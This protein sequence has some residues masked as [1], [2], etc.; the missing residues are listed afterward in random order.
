MPWTGLSCPWEL[1]GREEAAPGTRLQQQS[2]A[3]LS[4]TGWLGPIPPRQ[5][6]RLR[7]QAREVSF[8]PPRMLETPSPLPAGVSLGFSCFP[9]PSCKPSQPALGFPC[10]TSPP[11]CL[12]MGIWGNQGAAPQRGA[13]AVAPW[14]PLA[15]GWGQAA[16]IA[17]L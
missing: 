17:R 11:G 14:L 1:L 7:S 12:Q 10:K 6:Q 13:P 3:W 5:G 8:A 4:G 15:A 2:C 16:A 9:L